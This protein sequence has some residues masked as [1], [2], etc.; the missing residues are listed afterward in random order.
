M[1]KIGNSVIMRKHVICMITLVAI[2]CVFDV[3]AEGTWTTFTNGIYKNYYIMMLL[4]IKKMQ[5]KMV[6]QK[7]NFSKTVSN[8]KIG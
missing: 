7:V 3:S 8:N 6:L 2:I 4:K 1:K 5:K